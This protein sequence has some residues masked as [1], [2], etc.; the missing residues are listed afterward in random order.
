MPETQQRNL[1]IK[2]AVMSQLRALDPKDNQ[3]VQSKLELLVNDPVPDGKAKKRLQHLEGKLCR[4][5]AG[6]QRIFY[7]FNDQFVS[8]LRIAKRDESTYD[9]PP[10]AEF[11]SG[12]VA[13]DSV[14]DN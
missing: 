14:L 11:L 9:A 5:R 2:P 12:L 13:D 1:T 10:K 4:A 6:D 8:I 7:T 3:L